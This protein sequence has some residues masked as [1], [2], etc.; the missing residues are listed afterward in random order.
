[1]KLE[2]LEDWNMHAVF[3]I[4]ASAPLLVRMATNGYK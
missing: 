2:G 4:K 1:M 3:Y